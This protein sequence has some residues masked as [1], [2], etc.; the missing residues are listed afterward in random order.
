MSLLLRLLLSLTLL[1]NTAGGAWAAH[2]LPGNAGAVSQQASTQ[3]CHEHMAPAAAHHTAQH[4]PALA[5]AHGMHDGCCAQAGCD[6]LQHCGSAF[7]IPAGLALTPAPGQAPEP[8]M[9]AGRGLARPYQP[10]R[11]PIA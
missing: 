1:A 11:P 9:S 5:A 10:I 8:G 3:G 4:A 6:C 7:Q 2:G